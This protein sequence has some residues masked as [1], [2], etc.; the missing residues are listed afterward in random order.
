MKKVRA[1]NEFSKLLEEAMSNNVAE[2]IEECACSM[3]HFKC[4]KNI[5][6][7]MTKIFEGKSKPLSA[8]QP[9]HYIK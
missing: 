2:A 9:D 3:Y 4:D 7:V 1:E 6:E 8:Q 5:V